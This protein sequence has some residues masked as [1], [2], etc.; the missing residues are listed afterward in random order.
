[1]PTETNAAYETQWAPFRSCS[2]LDERLFSPKRIWYICDPASDFTVMNRHGTSWRFSSEDQLGIK[3][4]GFAR[5]FKWTSDEQFMYFSV[6]HPVDGGGDPFTPNA[7]AVLRMDLSNGK[8]TTVL[9]KPGN[10]LTDYHLYTYSLS[11]TSRRLAYAQLGDD[12]L[13][14]V[15]LHSDDDKVVPIEPEFAQT[16]D[17]AWSDDEK[18]LAYKLY[19][20]KKECKFSYSIRLLNLT[21]LDAVTFIKNESID[22][23][24]PPFP[25]FN[26]IDVSAD[27]VILQ[28]VNERWKYNIE[29]QRLELQG[30]VTPSP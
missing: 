20:E 25:E 10:L 19:T 7:E 11:P 21:D 3:D 15:D 12:E 1:M 26:I 4:V 9:G 16:G 14:I 2:P 6:M 28:K 23:C 8:V 30:T 13:H 24:T 22:Q 18:M 27:Q 17:F 5:L 29:S